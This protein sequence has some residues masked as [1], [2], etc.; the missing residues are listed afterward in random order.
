MAYEVVI[1]EDDADLV[2]LYEAAFEFLDE[3]VNCRIF[4]DAE[5]AM[6]YLMDTR[7][8]LIISDINLPNMSGLDLVRHLRRKSANIN[9]LVFIVS[10]YI[11]SE[12]K[13]IASEVRDIKIFEKPIPSIT[14][15]TKECLKSLKTRK[16][17]K[18]DTGL[19]DI[20]RDSAY[21]LLANYFEKE[22]IIGRSQLSPLNSSPQSLRGYI[23]FEGNGFNGSIAVDLG[24][25]FIKKFNETVQI[26][27]ELSHE[28]IAYEMANQL[29]GQFKAT[30]LERGYNITIGVPIAT[31]LEEV[32]EMR[33]SD[34]PV[35]YIPAGYIGSLF[36]IE[37]TMSVTHLD[38][39][40]KSG[41]TD[42]LEG[43]QM[44]LFD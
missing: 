15:F 26:D 11:H 43:G 9:S 21:M 6:V 3:E 22:P 24:E 2:D 16:E 10:G 44:I 34:N 29:A 36:R 14:E 33:T 25:G 12:A 18:Y 28:D 32:E 31:R 23:P 40:N 13:K 39:N 19:L 30:V 38:E 20:V 1:I 17:L 8:D 5:S 41:E 42:S 37:F 27:G 4:N 7:T 35:V